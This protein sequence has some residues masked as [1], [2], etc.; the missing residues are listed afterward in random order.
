MKGYVDLEI[1]RR[2]K[3]LAILRGL[4]V[5]DMICIALTEWTEQQ[6][7]PKADNSRR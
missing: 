2:V 3:S 5:E 1:Y 4:K 6:M 7:K